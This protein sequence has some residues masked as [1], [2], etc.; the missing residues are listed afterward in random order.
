MYR[1]NFWF[2]YLFNRYLY[3]RHNTACLSAPAESTRETSRVKIFILFSSTRWKC[4]TTDIYR[5]FSELHSQWVSILPRWCQLEVMMLLLPRQSL[6]SARVSSGSQ[7]S[8]VTFFPKCRVK[9]LGYDRL[10]FIRFYQLFMVSLE[11]FFKPFQLE[12]FL[13]IIQNQENHHMSTFLKIVELSGQ[14]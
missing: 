2:K 4:W 7:Q 3:T 9:F 1:F 10:F 13:V 12:S 6:V 8:V 14:R 5:W 11:P